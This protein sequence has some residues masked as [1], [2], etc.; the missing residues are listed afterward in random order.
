MS[1]TKNCILL[2]FV[3]SLMSASQA[4]ENMMRIM[5][6]NIRFANPGDG[7]HAWK[8]RKNFVAD[9][10][11]YNNAAII[12]VQEALEGQVHE[13]DSMLINHEWFG[14][15]REDGKNKGEFNPV[16]YNSHRFELLKNNT[17]W[18]SETPSRPGSMGWDAAC[19]RIVTWARFKDKTN[20]QHFYLF[21]THF[22]HQGTIARLR[23][24]E[25]IIDSIQAIAGNYP[26]ILTGDF[27]SLRRSGPYQHLTHWDN[28]AGLRDSQE[29]AEEGPYGP[30]TTYIGFEADFSKDMVIDYIFVNKKIN[31]HRHVV[32]DD[33]RG[34]NYPSDHLPVLTEIYFKK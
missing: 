28:A 34:E 7:A 23:S 25:I 2:L 6:F 1:I 32:V 4:Q 11:E 10:I 8:H 3:F 19:P 13:L 33:R 21:N 26:A 31:V 20:G 30:N 9:V 17:F 22:D 27:N 14:V 18:L 16:F 24:A 29:V 15:G 12:G 5:S